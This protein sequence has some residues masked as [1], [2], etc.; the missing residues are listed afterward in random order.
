MKNLAIIGG[1]PSALMLAAQIDVTKYRVTLYDQKNT[2]GRKFL[3]AGEG[4]LNLTFDSSIEDL[5]QKYIP[6]QFM[7]PYIRSFNNEDLRNW[8]LNIGIPTFSG[9]SHRVFPEKGI[10]PIEVLNQIIDHIKEKGVKIELNQ[11]WKGW[12]NEGNI[13]FENSEIIKADRVVFALGGASWSITGSD[14]HWKIPFEKKGIKVND[15]RAANCAFQIDWPAEF[16][17]VHRGKPLK[18][19]KVSFEESDSKGE[20]VITAFGIEGNA[21]YALS[22]KIQEEFLKQKEVIIHLDLKPTLSIKQ[23]Q[24]K[25]KNS[26]KSKVTEI[27]KQDLKLDKTAIALLKI[28]TSKEEFLNTDLI[29]KNIKSLA[30]N[31]VNAAPIDEAISTLGGVAIEEVDEN[32]QLK[33]IQNTHVLGEMLDWYAPTGGYLLQGSFSMGHALAQYLNQLDD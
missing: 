18:N 7:D 5:I 14:G 26:R 6:H 17:Q 28:I 32:L 29:A 23:I 13:I 4:G 11:T 20:L 9:S 25:I 15:F 27:L 1:G 21:I 33:K 24:N 8:F 3:V 12:D 10:K 22:Q 31:L 2:L 16:I 19:I 30:L